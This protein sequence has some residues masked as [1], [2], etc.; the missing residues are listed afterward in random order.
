MKLK[1]LRSAFYGAQDLQAAKAWYRKVFA[2]DPYFDQP[3]YV[4]FEVGG[5]ELG[6]QPSDGPPQGGNAYWGVDDAD[7]MA[8]HLI[9]QGATEVQPVQDVGEGIRVGS[10]R[11]PFG[12]T[13]GLIYN[14]HFKFRG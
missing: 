6:L 1:G 9:A 13:I 3:F 2:M 14:P 5:F 8:T 10:V 7:G 4:G 11:D 12:N